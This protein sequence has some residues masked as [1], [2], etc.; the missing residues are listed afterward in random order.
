M[1]VLSASDIN[2]YTL[3]DIIM[4]VPGHTVVYPEHEIGK[5][6]YDEFMSEE[7][8]ITSANMLN[9]SQPWLSLPGAYRRI[10]GAPQ[11]ARVRI[12]KYATLEVRSYDVL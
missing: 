8:G 3:F 6:R 10:L 4:P 9:S 12:A 5:D 11:Y 1:K 2:N 7:L